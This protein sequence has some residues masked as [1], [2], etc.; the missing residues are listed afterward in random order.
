MGVTLDTNTLLVCSMCIL[1][2]FQVV[3]FGL[4]AKAFA[5]R[6]GL[7]PLQEGMER[8]PSKTSLEA[9]LFAG[10][11]VGL[12]G[13]ALLGLALYVWEEHQFGELSYSGSPRI[14]ILAV[15]LM[16]LGVQVMFS[17]FFLSVLR[18]KLR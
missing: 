3:C 1:V 5:I 10:L 4:F 14:V 9:G 8:I 17:S 2:G 6:E 18:L 15:T 11:A 13:A 12:A 7:L 16:M